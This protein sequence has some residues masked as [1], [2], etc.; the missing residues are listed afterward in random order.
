MSIAKVEKNVSS[1]A[2]VTVDAQPKEKCYEYD[3][4]IG[5]FGRFISENSL[6][7]MAARSLL[8]RI[9][10]LDDAE[11]AVHSSVNQGKDFAITERG[12]VRLHIRGTHANRTNASRQKKQLHTFAF[13][14]PRKTGIEDGLFLGIGAVTPSGTSPDYERRAAEI[15]EEYALAGRN[16]VSDAHP[17]E[18][19]FLPQCCFWI[20]PV[21]EL[22]KCQLRRSALPPGHPK[23]P[24]FAAWGDQPERCCEVWRSALDRVRGTGM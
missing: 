12:P 21:N 23:L 24:K 7:R 10:A 1:S 5:G 19:D 20:L 13:E 4:L 6:A 3:P 11:F 22:S 15:A 16:F 14:S 8:S 2:T 17:S 18:A 9:F